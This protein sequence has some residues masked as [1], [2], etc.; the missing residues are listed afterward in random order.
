MSVQ[1]PNSTSVI[2]LLSVR[3]LK[4]LMYAGVGKALKEMDETVQVNTDKVS[5]TSDLCN[6]AMSV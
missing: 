6:L 3:T 1:V 2:L 4:D 5:A